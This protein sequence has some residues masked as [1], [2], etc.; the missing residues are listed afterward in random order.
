MVECESLETQ[1]N[2]SMLM[3]GTLMAIGGAVFLVYDYD[4]RFLRQLC[5][6][7]RMSRVRV[8]RKRGFAV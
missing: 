1:E 3:L 6:D 5:W 4:Q 7:M 2:E 8:Y